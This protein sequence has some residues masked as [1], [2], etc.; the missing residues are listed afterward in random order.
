[1]WRIT[2]SLT[3]NNEV[4]RLIELF[5]SINQL[6]AALVID[7][8]LCKIRPGRVE[9]PKSKGLVLWTLLAI[10]VYDCRHPY[11]TVSAEGMEHERPPE[12]RN[13]VSTV[14]FHGRDVNSIFFNQSNT[15]AL[16]K[17]NWPGSTTPDQHV[18]LA[19]RWKS[20]ISFLSKTAASCLPAVD[21]NGCQWS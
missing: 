8:S 7:V 12:N 15:H 9:S 16:A 11:L 3:G 5:F 2:L 21:F 20:D 14:G 17:V 10:I 19:W 6:V 13:L 18:G 1:M 4:Y